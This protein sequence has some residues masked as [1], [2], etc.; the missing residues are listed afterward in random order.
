MLPYKMLPYK[1]HLTN[2]GLA[3]LIIV[4]ATPFIRFW[5][6]GNS[7][8]TIAMFFIV[9]LLA[10]SCF[11]KSKEHPQEM[12][13][14]TWGIIA[15]SV[16]YTLSALYAV[17]DYHMT[18]TTEKVQIFTIIIYLCTWNKTETWL[19]IF[20]TYLVSFFFIDFYI[21]NPVFF[22]GDRAYV[23]LNDDSY[24]DPN[25]VGATFIIPGIYS[26]I[27]LLEK[28]KWWYKAL[29][30]VIL[31]A[32]LY[33][34]FIG[35]SRSCMMAMLFGL[36]V[37]EWK[38]ISASTIFKSLIAIGA[39]FLVIYPIF[40]NVLPASFIE[41][42]TIDSVAESG[43]SH[44]TDLWIDYTERWFNEGNIATILFGY[45]KETCVTYFGKAAHQTFLE[46][47]WSIGIVGLCLFIYILKKMYKFLNA[48]KSSFAIA[49]F[50]ATILWS[51]TITANNQLVFWVLFFQS[52]MIA[53]SG[54][55]VGI[56]NKYKTTC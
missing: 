11:F 25:M 26:G 7:V 2:R 56:F 38:N 18:F 51:C 36:I 6:F 35:G 48:T 47:L 14:F 27:V 30:A 40:K 8:L 46:Y 49:V 13:P 15:I 55:K 43:G 4:I 3:A 45:G 54:L 32:I 31:I 12:Y 53:K 50:F 17:F 10:L 21:N 42:W 16:L 29:H 44:R 24:L 33:G 19:S 34:S 23:P 39:F 5:M 20:I 52:Y 22:D 41:R 28:N 1:E 37:Y 9:P